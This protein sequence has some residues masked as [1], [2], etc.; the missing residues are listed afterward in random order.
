MKNLIHNFP[1]K[2]KSLKNEFQLSIPGHLA[3]L[4]YQLNVKTKYSFSKEL[5]WFSYKD[6]RNN[7]WLFESS[8]GVSLLP[9]TMLQTERYAK[10]EKTQKISYINNKLYIGVSG[11]GFYTLN[12][13]LDALD[14]L[15]E[16]NIPHSEIYHIK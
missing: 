9:N 4:D 11:K 10:N 1:F 7:V 12:P 14:N 8:K 2:C 13:K 15:E 6:S 16:F 3:V 5:G